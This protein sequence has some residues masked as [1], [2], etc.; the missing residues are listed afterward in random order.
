MNDTVATESSAQSKGES[1][2]Q[3]RSSSLRVGGYLILNIFPY[4]INPKLEP[5]QLT[6]GEYQNNN[7][8]ILNE[9]LNKHEG[10]FV[11][12]VRA[13]NNALDNIG[14]VL[15][16]RQLH[17]VVSDVAVYSSI[18]NN[19]WSLGVGETEQVIAEYNTSESFLSTGDHVDRVGAILHGLCGWA[20]KTMYVYNEIAS[21]LHEGM[22]LSPMS[23]IDPSMCAEYKN[24][25][26]Q[27]LQECSKAKA[28][29]S[30]M[31]YITELNE[32]LRR[33]E[34]GAIS[35]I[36]PPFGETTL[37]GELWT[38]PLATR[39][40]ILTSTTDNPDGYLTKI[41]S[42]HYELKRKLEP[43]ES[44]RL[45]IC[46]DSENATPDNPPSQSS[47]PSVPPARSNARSFTQQHRQLSNDSRTII[48]QHSG[49]TIKDSQNRMNPK[50]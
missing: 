10:P 49:P 32:L 30:N 23:E 2:H 45:N 27:E 50:M 7:R 43:S 19:P 46:S 35:H 4:M 31:L 36:V 48:H 28:P 21:P 44:R 3:V 47:S 6:K 26:L 13:V 5:P 18:H 22:P 34:H 29:L 8:R 12:I 16:D 40:S 24:R 33:V 14:S 38:L 39:T 9:L 17:S 37:L 11:R 20:H 42:R 41:V 15:G 1:H 25:I